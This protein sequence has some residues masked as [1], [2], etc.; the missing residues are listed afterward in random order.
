MPGIYTKPFGG[1][2]GKPFDMTVVK[3]LGLRT[4]K[5]VGQIRINGTPHGRTGGN[6]PG[7]ITLGGDDDRGNRA[8]A[9]VNL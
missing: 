8:A 9:P 1:E 5:Y 2:G 7:S 3:E 6:D 4:A